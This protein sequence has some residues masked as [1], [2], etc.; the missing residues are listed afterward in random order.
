MK[1]FLGILKVS[2]ER[3][4]IR[5]WKMIRIRGS[6]PSHNVTDPQHWC[7]YLILEDQSILAGSP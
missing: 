7:W 2:E 3:S 1:I 5:S 4:Q 6:D